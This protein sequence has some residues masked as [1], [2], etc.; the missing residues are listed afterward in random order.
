MTRVQTNRLKPPHPSTWHSFWLKRSDDC[1]RPVR[2]LSP[3]TT[4]TYIIGHHRKY[5]SPRSRIYNVIVYNIIYVSK[6]TCTVCI[7]YYYECDFMYLPCSTLNITPF[8]GT[9]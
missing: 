2:E 7:K 3:P 1:S 4:A 8:T 9:D 5:G 6:M